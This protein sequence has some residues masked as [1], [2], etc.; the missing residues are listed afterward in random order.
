M[1]AVLRYA[2]DAAAA[3][4]GLA[5]GPAR[6]NILSQQGN[7]TTLAAAI[8]FPDDDL[9]VDQ[10]VLN[11]LFSTIKAY[12]LLAAQPSIC[13]AHWWASAWGGVGWGPLGTAAVPS[14]CRHS[15]PG[16]APMRIFPQMMCCSR[17]L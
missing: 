11:T 3:A 6:L 14:L 16:F 5:A 13:D 2:A 10:C 4:W 9:V 1:R 15:S 7:I 17:D 12:R 8:A